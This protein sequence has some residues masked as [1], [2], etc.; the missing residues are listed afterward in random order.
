LPDVLAEVALA[1]L[2]VDGRWVPVASLDFVAVFL[3]PDFEELVLEVL[4]LWVGFAGVAV[5]AP[6]WAK[7]SE[8]AKSAAQPTVAIFLSL[9]EFKPNTHLM[10]KRLALRP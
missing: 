8:L 6:V 10:P 7:E 9:S 2:L 4:A 5:E 3:E 1:V